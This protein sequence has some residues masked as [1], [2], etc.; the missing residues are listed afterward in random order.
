MENSEFMHIVATF[1]VFYPASPGDRARF[2]AFARD[3]DRIII[4]RALEIIKVVETAKIAGSAD[5][6]GELMAVKAKLAVTEEKL[7]TSEAKCATLIDTLDMIV[8][9]IPH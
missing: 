7:A 6:A 2:S 1:E 9:K 4:E 3:E 5:A 8:K